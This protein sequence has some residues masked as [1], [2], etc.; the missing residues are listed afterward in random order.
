MTGVDLNGIMF[1]F[2][3]ALVLVFAMK[4]IS[5]IFQARARIWSEKQY[6]ALAEQSVAMQSESQVTLSAMQAN[7]SHVA[8]SLAEIEK[9]LKQVE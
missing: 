1:A 9:I 2:F 4:Y 6:R 8:S 7:L 3:L 5:A